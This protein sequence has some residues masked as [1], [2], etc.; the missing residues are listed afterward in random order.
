MNYYKI[1][2]ENETHRG[3]KYHDGLN[4]DPK[5]FN[6]NGSCK[7]GGIYFARKDILA[8]LNY[9][10]WIRKVTLPADALIYKDPELPEKWKANKFIL[11]KRERITSKVIKRLVKEGADIHANNNCALRW[12]A[13]SG[14]LDVVK[15]LVEN[16]ADIHAYNDLALRW[17]AG[18]GHLDVVKF[19]VE[20]GADIHADNDYALRWTAGK[21][22]LEVVKFLV[23]NGADIHADND[24]ALRWAAGKGHLEVVKFLE[25]HVTNLAKQ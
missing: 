14:H 4:I 1:L 10:P 16:D 25:N 6:P 3:F 22:H 24:Y 13:G 11:G 21:G 17:A 19:L 7:K 8:F 12:A 9:G 20:K 15:F 18:S 5:P 23:K 2:K